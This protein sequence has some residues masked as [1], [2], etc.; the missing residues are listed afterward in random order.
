MAEKIRG[1]CHV[2]MDLRSFIMFTV[3]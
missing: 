2:F 3:E 1:F